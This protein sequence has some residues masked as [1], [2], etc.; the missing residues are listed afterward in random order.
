VRPTPT[1]TLPPP[2]PG[3]YQQN[4]AAVAY[5]T[6]WFTNSNG[7]HSGGS[8]V[9]AMDVGSAAT[10]TFTGTEV[11][12]IGFRDPWSGQADVY[13]D[14]VLQLRVDTYGAV[15]QRQYPMYTRTGL[16]PGTHT[17]RIQVTG[18][19][20]PAS[21]GL[22]VWI[23]AFDVRGSAGGST[24]TA[25]PTTP[26]PTPTLTPT[27]TSPP[28]ATPTPTATMVPRVTATST[29]TATMAGTPTPTSAAPV[30][31]EQNHSSAAYAA[32]PWFTH[33]SS[34]H[35]GGSAALAMDA[36]SQV[37]FSFTGPGARWIGFKD[38]WTGIA[39]VY[40]D[41]VFQASVDGYSPTQQNNVTLY[42]ATG[43]A[44]GPHT[45]QIHVPGTR[46][47]ASG[48]AWVWIDAFEV[49]P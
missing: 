37:T 47:P 25:T 3:R 7:A 9:L 16:T 46:S 4:H 32:G 27:A 18:T 43:L 2:T 21:S 11:T 31:F 44:A 17:L 35:S 36:G 41:G 5:T 28:R 42:S 38:P 39:N 48:G 49:L 12:W 33:T 19:R 45:M 26:S 40:V 15:E 24:P 23:D 20:N 8:A 14:G 13:V 34:G 10:F 29:P 1:A 6:G 30:R 22:W